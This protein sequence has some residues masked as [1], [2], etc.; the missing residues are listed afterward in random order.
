MRK[1]FV[2]LVNNITVD[3]IGIRNLYD[4]AIAN[5]GDPKL[6]LP[7]D[8]AYRWMVN[9]IRHEYTNYEQGLKQIHKLK[10]DEL[11]YQM[12]K[13]AVLDKISSTYPNLSEE[14]YKQKN[15]VEMVTKVKRSNND[16]TSR[17]RKN[18]R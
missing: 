6:E 1:K 11:N 9:T 4:K 17:K 15:L 3:E 8:V 14:C 5:N 18:S 2:K 13:N 7:E 10:C 16:A 12:Y